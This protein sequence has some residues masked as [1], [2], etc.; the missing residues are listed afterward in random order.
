MTQLRQTMIDAMLVR[1]FST[2]THRSYLDAVGGL[3]RHY[4][5]SPDQLTTEEIT[6]YA[7]DFAGLQRYLDTPEM[8]ARAKEALG[9]TD[10]ATDSEAE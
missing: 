4:H 6:K 2:R 9:M 7:G 1:G 5:R 8:V 10:E 3:A